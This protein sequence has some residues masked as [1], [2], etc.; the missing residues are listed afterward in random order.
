LHDNERGTEAIQLQYSPQ[1]PAKWRST[2]SFPCPSHGHTREEEGL[3]SR[4]NTAFAE[5]ERRKK[6]VDG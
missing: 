1:Q 5:E 3:M 2:Q 4:T 6:K